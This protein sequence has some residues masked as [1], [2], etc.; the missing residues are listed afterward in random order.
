MM[1]RFILIV[2]CACSSVLFAQP[3]GQSLIQEGIEFH[4]QG[5]YSEAIAK[6]NQALLTNKDNLHALAEKAY[7]QMGLK[8][9]SEA[10]ATCKKA[11]KIKTTDNEALKLVY[12]TY[13]NALDLSGKPKEAIKIYNKGLKEHPGFYS[14]HYNKG[15]TY[16]GLR[17][18]SSATDAFQ[19]SAKARPSHASSFLALGRMLAN[20]N[21]NIPALLSYLRFHAIEPDSRRAAANFEFVQEL[22]FS[23]VKKTG[24]NSI[25]ISLPSASLDEMGKENKTDN[26]FRSIELIL[27]M[28][29]ALDLGENQDEYTD[30]ERFEKKLTS[31]FQMLDESKKGN[32]GFYWEFL[33]P[34]FMEL[35]AKNYEKVLAHLVFSNREDEKVNAWLTDN[36][37]KVKSFYEWSSGYEW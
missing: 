33:A 27:S 19:L 7:S 30:V 29:S 35:H 36:Q 14:L 4:D 34:Y 10:I 37:S 25:S 1:K 20:E 21:E 13:G 12:T 18:W 5:K 6:Y 8:A 24:D 16:S 31:M 11:L 9:Y 32:S 22:V 17:E 28:Q 23:N 2:V 15:V 3:N 26:S